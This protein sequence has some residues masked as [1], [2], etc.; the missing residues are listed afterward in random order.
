MGCRRDGGY[1]QAA[2]ARTPGEGSNHLHFNELVGGEVTNHLHFNELVGGKVVDGLHFNELV[3]GEVVDG[4]HFNRLVGGE[5]VNHL[6][7]NELV[8]GEVVDGLRFNQ[9]VKQIRSI[10]DAPQRCCPVQPRQFP[11]SCLITDVPEEENPILRA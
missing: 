5:V 10:A 1:V 4:L 2:G 9:L 3:G 7:F 6:R 11:A 8:G